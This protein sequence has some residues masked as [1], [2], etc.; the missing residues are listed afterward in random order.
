MIGVK[1]YDDKKH[2]K[3]FNTADYIEFDWVYDETSEQV[4]AN[5]PKAKITK[6]IGR[7]EL[8]ICGSGKKFKKCCINRIQ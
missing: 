1:H 4:L 3:L 6:K 8:C 5:I 2:T 7:N